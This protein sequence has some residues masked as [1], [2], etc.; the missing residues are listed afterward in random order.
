[1]SQ[2]DSQPS[3]ETTAIAAASQP[4]ESH[5]AADTSRS[6][7]TSHPRDED[8]A[9][10]IRIT[11]SPSWWGIGF[12]V[13][14]VLFSGGVYIGQ[15]FLVDRPYNAGL[16]IDPEYL[17]FGEVWAEEQFKWR[18]PI[19]NTSDREVGIA[20]FTASCQCSLIEPPSLTISPH[21]TAEV[22]AT[23][24][25]TKGRDSEPYEST[26]EF[27]IAIHPI[28]AVATSRPPGFILRGKAKDAFSPSPRQVELGEILSQTVGERATIRLKT[29]TPLSSVTA[30]PQP[31]MEIEIKPV[32]SESLPTG[33][34]P[35][36]GDDSH[37]R[38]TSDSTDYLLTVTPSA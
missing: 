5:V 27:E 7:K 37:R 33:K 38:L 28:V 9:A 32:E 12:I 8:N 36:V 24:D 29:A 31:D 11:P 26:R 19:E 18:I 1:M 15:T 22:V 35:S 13:V 34:G 10:S 17:D 21:S 3:A 30:L 4:P 23:I 2:M 14:A 25:L 20:E 16:R 6:A